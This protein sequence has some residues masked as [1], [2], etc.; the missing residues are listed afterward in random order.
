MKLL[1]LCSIKYFVAILLLYIYIYSPAIQTLSFGL[2]KII[3]SIALVYVLFTH[4]LNKARKIFVN[5][6][7]YLTLIVITSLLISAIHRDNIFEGIF[8]YDM[9]LMIEVLLVPYVFYCIFTLRLGLQIDKV[10]IGNAIIASIITLALLTNPSWADTMKNQVLRI[11]EV[12][13]SN[14]K[15]RGFGFSDGLIFG[16]PVVQGFCGAFIV[17]GFVKVKPICYLMLL[18]ILIS[19]FVNARS[20]IV[21][22]F[23][24]LIIVVFNSS[25][26]KNIYIIIIGF[27]VVII[28]LLIFYNSNNDQL[29]ESVEWGVSTFNI[30]IDIIQGNDAENTDALLHDMVFLPTDFIDWILGS[31]VNAFEEKYKGYGTS[32]IGFCIRTIYGGIIYMLLWFLLWVYMYKRCRK[33]NYKLAFLLFVSLVYLNWKSDFFIVNPSCRFFFFVYAYIILDVKFLTSKK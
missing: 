14:F 10:L 9:F 11:P 22:I 20:G 21:P 6:Y 8:V 5:E 32:D 2:D 7:K 31:G 25:V 15:F 23:V 12:L 13:L 19:I 18:P 29:K 17:L 33:I 4:Q 24:A 1:L 16:Y 26:K 28:G 3:F 27:I 30:I